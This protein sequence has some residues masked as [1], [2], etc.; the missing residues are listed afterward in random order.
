VAGS[1]ERVRLGTY[2]V[3]VAL[4]SADLLRSKVK[5]EMN[6]YSVLSMNLANDSLLTF[7]KLT[8]KISNLLSN[9][10]TVS[11]SISYCLKNFMNLNILTSSLGRNWALT[12]ASKART[13]IYLIYK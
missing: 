4:A 9:S 11:Y 3:M 8:E 13:K 1:S 12:I 5:V 7:S 6:S 10:S 2:L